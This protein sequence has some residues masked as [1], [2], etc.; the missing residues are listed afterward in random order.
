MCWAALNRGIAL[1]TKHGF[2][3]PL[4]RWQQI[5]REMREAIETKGYD[6]ERG[7]FVQSFETKELDAALLLLPDVEFVAYDDPRMLRTVDAIRED[8]TEGGLVLRYR[9]HDGLSGRE[10]VFLAC[11]FWLVECLARQRRR[12]DAARIFNNVIRCAND[13]GLFAEEFDPASGEVLGN[14][15]Q[16]L[17]I[18]LTSPRHWR[19][20]AG[21]S[22]CEKKPEREAPVFGLLA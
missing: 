7:V 11:T 19:C 1:A 18:S 15:P 10:G 6:Q 3:A 12:E 8:L 14:F 16:G 13:V 9:T 22:A 17:L 5:K 4:A 21:R 20:S 2:D